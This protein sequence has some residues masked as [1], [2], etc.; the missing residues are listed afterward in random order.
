MYIVEWYDHEGNR[1]ARA[2]DS[3]EAAQLEAATLE[4]EFENVAIIY[5]IEI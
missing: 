3:Q 2:F 1:H 4:E 5:E